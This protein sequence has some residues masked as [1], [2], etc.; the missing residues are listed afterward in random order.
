MENIIFAISIVNLALGI[1]I[2]YK[3]THGQSESAQALD[4]MPYHL[5]PSPLKSKSAN[6]TV[7]K[8]KPV[9]ID[10]STAYK[11]E[12]ENLNQNRE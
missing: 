8:R 12:Q 3:I 6:I 10:D 5:Y 1:Y 4:Q 9:I 11:I 7:P 2:L